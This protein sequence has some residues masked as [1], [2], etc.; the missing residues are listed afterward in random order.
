MNKFKNVLHLNSFYILKSNYQLIIPKKDADPNR[1]Y[2]EA[3]IEVDYSVKEN[4]GN[5]SFKI[6]TEL[7]I[8]LQDKS[9]GYSIEVESIGEFS[10]IEH[11]LISPLERQY[12]IYYIATGK[13]I[14]YIRGFI[15]PLT[16]HYPLGKS[17]FRDINMEELYKK[18]IEQLK[19]IKSSV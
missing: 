13:C 15:G 19:K 8:N 5:K 18:K 2:I 16:A 1:V 3:P 10:F 4:K 14:D 12:Y 6:Y 17:M 11:E 9:P 7:R